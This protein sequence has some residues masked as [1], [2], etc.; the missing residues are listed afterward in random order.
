MR[1]SNSSFIRCG[2][3]ASHCGFLGVSLSLSRAASAFLCRIAK[4]PGNNLIKFV[5][6][7]SLVERYDTWPAVAV[8]RLAIERTEVT[9]RLTLAYYEP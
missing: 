3:S 1:Y 5:D 2:G 7:L 4:N 6:R 8:P 9:S